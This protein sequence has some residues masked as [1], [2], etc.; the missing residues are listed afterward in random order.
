MAR[1]KC[2]WGQAHIGGPR[3]EWPPVSGGKGSDQGSSGLDSVDSSLSAVEIGV[4][5]VG[6][7]ADKRLCTSTLTTHAI[8]LS[9]SLVFSTRW[10]SMSARRQISK[11]WSEWWS[12]QLLLQSCEWCW[13][14]QWQ[15]ISVSKTNPL[16]SAQSWWWCG[17]MAC[18]RMIAHAKV[19]IIFAVR[20]FIAWRL[21]VT[22]KVLST[23]FHLIEIEENDTFESIFLYLMVGMVT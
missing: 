1:C 22:T 21:Q 5:I 15:L 19:I 12:L 20:C 7:T 18:T 4:P 6:I 23:L 14:L 17:T 9:S 10:E 3:R 11:G 13:W 16:S 8:R 2:L